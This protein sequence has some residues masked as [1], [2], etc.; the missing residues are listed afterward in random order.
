MLTERLPEE[1]N[2]RGTEEQ[3]FGLE[4]IWEKGFGLPAGFLEWRLSTDKQG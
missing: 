1:L 2:D 4:A 3:R